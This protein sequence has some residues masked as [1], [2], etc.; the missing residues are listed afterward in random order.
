MKEP[1]SAARCSTLSNDDSLAHT[2]EMPQSRSSSQHFLA[3]QDRLALGKM[4]EEEFP[5]ELTEALLPTPG[6]Y[7]VQGW[8]D[9]DG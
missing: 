3:S 2:T 8:H 9:I 1:S 7:E 6:E 5:R 4:D